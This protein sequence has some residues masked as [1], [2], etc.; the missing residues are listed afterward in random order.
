MI[1]IMST[2]DHPSD[3]SVFAGVVKASGD[4]SAPDTWAFNVGGT[5]LL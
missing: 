5:E 2:L 3:V 4:F 1:L